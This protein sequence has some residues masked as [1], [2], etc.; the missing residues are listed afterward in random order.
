MKVCPTNRIKQE[1][2]YTRETHLLSIIQRK[3]QSNKV[4][5]SQQIQD[6]P[7]V[8]LRFLSKSILSHGINLIDTKSYKLL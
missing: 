4:C 7:A 6:R 8:N 3:D 2:V 5:V 1:K